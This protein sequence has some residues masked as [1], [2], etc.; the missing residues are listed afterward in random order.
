MYLCFLWIKVNSTAPGWLFIC[1]ELKF[2]AVEYFS[3]CIK[4][5]N[6]KF[7]NSAPS[8]SAAAAAAASS[9]VPQLTY[10][11]LEEHINKVIDLMHNDLTHP[12]RQYGIVVTLKSKMAASSVWPYLE[13]LDQ[14]Y[15]TY[16]KAQT[17]HPSHYLM[18]R[19]QP[20]QNTW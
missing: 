15:V 14:F 18:A 12:E 17:N 2:V 20:H 11:Q 3:N 9:S 19:G 16:L 10:K 13:I 5:E 4:I 7:L 1:R 6:L 8:S